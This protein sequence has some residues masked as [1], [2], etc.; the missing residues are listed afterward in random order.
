VTV[1]PVGRYFLCDGGT[2]GQRVTDSKLVGKGK[3][4]P[5][6]GGGASCEG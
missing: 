4:P 5:V 6:I 1:A 3:R 2:W